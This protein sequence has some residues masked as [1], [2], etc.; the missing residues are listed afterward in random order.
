M[1]VKLKNTV[2]CEH[3][4]TNGAMYEKYCFAGFPNEKICCIV[5]NKQC[6]KRCNKSVAQ[7][8]KGGA[9]DRQK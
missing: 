5:C 7:L 4:W 2:I 1:S 3:C 6:L 9:Y 8:E